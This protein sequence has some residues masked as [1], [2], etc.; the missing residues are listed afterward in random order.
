[1]EPVTALGVAA[2]ATQFFDIAR[3][4]IREYQEN[5]QPPVSQTAFK[6]TAVDLRGLSSTF[7]Q[8][9]QPPRDATNSVHEHQ[10]A[11]DQLILDCDNTTQ[12]LIDLLNSVQP[13]EKG[14]AWASIGQAIASVWNADKIKSLEE[15]V[16]TYQNQLTLRLLAYI[17]AKQGPTPF[18]SDDSLAQL[19]RSDS[20]II[21]MINT[22]HTDTLREAKERHSSVMSVVPS[23]TADQRSLSMPEMDLG[24]GV[25]E[26]V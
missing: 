12:E 19:M 4:L 26:M 1:M 2:A 16:G 17:E 3:N 15:R 24:V 5:R 20:R 13:D 11:L 23:T 25:T 7:K 6:N 18:D 21:N 22:S 14:S 9:P 10:K 8:R